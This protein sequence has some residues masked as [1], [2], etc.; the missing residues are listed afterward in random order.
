MNR[1]VTAGIAALGFLSA[2]LT[3]AP[4]R[5]QE[6]QDKITKYDKAAPGG[7]SVVT[8]TVKSEDLSGCLVTVGKGAEITIRWKDIKSVAYAGSPEFTRAKGYADAG[9]VG[10]AIQALEELRKKTEL[11]AILKPHVLNLL[12]SCF[13]RDGQ[14]DK[15]ID[16]YSELFKQFPKCQFLVFGGGENLIN[17][18]LAK[19]PAAAK[20]AQAALEALFTG[21]KSAGID[22]TPLNLL[23]GRVQEAAGD[24]SSAAASYGQVLSAASSDADAKAAAELGI[25]RC[26]VGQKKAGEA[27][28]KFRGLVT[29]DPAPTSLVLAGAW[30]GLADI[31]LANG[32]AGKDA[33]QSSELIMDALFDYL[34]GCVLYPPASGEP[35]T[36]Y[37]RA[38]RGAADCF[39]ALSELE[40]DDKKKTRFRQ[41][42]AERLEHLQTKF[43]NSP[44]LSGK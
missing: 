19:G 5:A 28:S 30:N 2:V 43:P 17:A 3:A 21:A 13:Q 4:A 36:E 42:A 1:V 32:R 10:E 33:A 12:G 7:T 6:E 16:A 38:V 8:G 18:Y 25:A 15:A 22:T 24:F 27:E 35:T 44:Y 31:A 40:K 23:R 14:F 29:R 37:E 39:K 11:R 34:R 41:C 26:L 9:S 20:D